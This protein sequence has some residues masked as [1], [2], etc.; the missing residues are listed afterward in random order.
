MKMKAVAAGM[1]DREREVAESEKTQPQFANAATLEEI[2]Q[3]AYELHLD[4]GCERGCDLDDWL[5]AKRGL[6]RSTGLSR[7]TLQSAPAQKSVCR[8]MMLIKTVQFKH[9]SPFR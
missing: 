5:H 3:R 9:K 2:R 4:R 7:H 8:V 1:E 6:R